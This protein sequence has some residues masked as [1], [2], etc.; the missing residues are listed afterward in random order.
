[1]GYVGRFSPEKRL[2]DLLATSR[3]LAALHRLLLVGDGPLE[4]QMRQ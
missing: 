2:G 4:P 3:L 1:M